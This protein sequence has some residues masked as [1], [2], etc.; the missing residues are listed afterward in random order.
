[1]TLHFTRMLLIILAILVCMF[2]PFIPGR[3][4]G[5]A[6]TLSFIA[7][8]LAVAGLVLVPIGILWLIFKRHKFA[9]AA[10]LAGCVMVFGVVAAALE[11]RH[12]SFGIIFLL[13]YGY[14]FFR[15]MRGIKNVHA[16]AAWYLIL[17]PII[18]A[19][20]RFIFIG[21]ATEYSRNYAIGQSR[22]LIQGIETYYQRNG[23]FPVSL[24]ALH[25]DIEPFVTGIEKYHYEPNGN[26]YNLFFEQFSHV[27]GVREIVLY[28][29][30]DEH[31]M[32]S[33][34]ADLIELSPQQLSLQRGYFTVLDLPQPHWKRFLFD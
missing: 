29:K 4:D 31:V 3:Y 14:F 15:V 19:L 20:V 28:N 30:L 23:V 32:T 8:V 5:L 27:L 25:Q 22:P 21:P 24:L 10:L 6:V 34:D 13:L 1:M 16:S 33:H 11:T 7:Q 9:L 2:L 26:A 12:L 17:I 18:T